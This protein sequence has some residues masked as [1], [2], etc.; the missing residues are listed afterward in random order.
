MKILF[1]GQRGVPALIEKA[2]P[3]RRVQAL[4]QALAE[5]G[6]DVAVSCGQ[7]FVSQN[8]SRFNGVELVHLFSLDPA[9][10]GGWVHAFL[11]LVIIWWRQSDVVHVHG[12]KLA[13]LC[14]VAAFLTP[15]STFVWTVDAIPS[16]PLWIV[17]PI[18]RGAAKVFDAVTVPTRALQYV[19]ARDLRVTT[20]YVPDGYTSAALP[21]IPLKHFGL[22]HGQQY[23]LTLA[24]TPQATRAVARACAQAGLRRKLVVLKEQRGVWTRL[25]KRFPFLH[26]A[27]E[28]S[29]RA[30]ATLL[31]QASVVVVADNDAPHDAI[32][33]TMDYGRAVVA[34][35]PSPAEE[36]LGGAAL[37]V[38]ADDATGL[39]AVLKSVAGSC[40][41]QAAWG[42]KAQRRARAHFTWPRIV[43]EYVALYHYPQVK[44]V[45]LD[46]AR[47]TFLTELP[48]VR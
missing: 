20:N 36:V 19:L 3:E 31:A 14:R 5:D 23:V 30:L 18:V 32:L 13:A 34:T 37:F 43:P 29:G 24:G 6:H 4:A 11:E 44:P 41:R 16:W 45:T 15:R 25:A 9:K 26:F 27:G 22:R 46:S 17:R 2:R 40:R 42:A 21:N 8:I 48:A 38:K 47:Q 35:T 10:A 7:P 12:W 28:Q 39:T 1:V 33:Q